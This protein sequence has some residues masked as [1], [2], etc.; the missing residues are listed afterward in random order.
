MGST[1]SLEGGDRSN[2]SLSGGCNKKLAKEIWRRNQ[3]DL[4]K[5][6]LE[7]VITRLHLHRRAL[8]VL[9]NINMKLVIENLRKLTAVS[10]RHVLIGVKKP[11]YSMS[12]AELLAWIN[13]A[14]IVC[15]K[16][17]VM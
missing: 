1:A 8:R 14:I 9:R 10:K 6:R 11:T 13:K 12:R 2:E 17:N 15:F 7:F 16:A 5:T 4:Q 3:K